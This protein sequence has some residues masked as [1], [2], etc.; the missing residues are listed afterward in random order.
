MRGSVDS[1]IL[2]LLDAD[3]QKVLDVPPNLDFK[4]PPF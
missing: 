4:A 1:L 2:V 3:L